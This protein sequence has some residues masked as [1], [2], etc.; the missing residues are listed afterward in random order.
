MWSLALVSGSGPV[1]NTITNIYLPLF[2]FTAFI[3]MGVQKCMKATGEK[4][5]PGMP[6]V[7]EWIGKTN[8]GVLIYHELL[9][10]EAL[11]L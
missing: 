4:K 2:S 6:F 9:L 3:L 11:W 8:C 1:K 10:N 5:P 7:S